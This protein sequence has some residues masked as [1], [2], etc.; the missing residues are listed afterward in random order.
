MNSND[1]D[2]FD[3]EVGCPTLNTEALRRVLEVETVR[4]AESTLEIPIA[5]ASDVKIEVPIQE[6]LVS[7]EENYNAID[8]AKD[9]LKSIVDIYSLGLGDQEIVIMNSHLTEK[10]LR[11]PIVNAPP[12]IGQSIVPGTGVIQKKSR[13]RVS[14]SKQVAKKIQECVIA[15]GDEEEQ[16]LLE[17]EEEVRQAQELEAKTTKIA[18][19][20]AEWGAVDSPLSSA[21]TSVSDHL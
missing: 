3:F 2:E 13:R 21:D 8:G 10:E 9:A 7:T 19:L 1:P 5:K 18:A 14:G 16:E 4:V 15:E 17:Q 20:E 12:A 11:T 6:P